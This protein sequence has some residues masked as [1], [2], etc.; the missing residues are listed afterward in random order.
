MIWTG[1]NKKKK[2]KKNSF[3]FF[4]LILFHV[5]YKVQN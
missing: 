5:L 3:S 4:F 2:K 1:I